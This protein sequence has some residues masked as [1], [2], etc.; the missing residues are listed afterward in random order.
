MVLVYFSIAFI[1]CAMVFQALQSRVNRRLRR[2]QAPQGVTPAP[3]STMMLNPVPRDH[4]R[5]AIAVRQGDNC[6]ASGT[7]LAKGL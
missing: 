3:F 7:R 5:D 1:L 4:N 6:T 2:Q